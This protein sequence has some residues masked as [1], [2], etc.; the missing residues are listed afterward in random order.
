[1]WFI[2]RINNVDKCMKNNINETKN[3]NNYGDK[4]Y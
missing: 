1:M 4:L 2:K 3:L